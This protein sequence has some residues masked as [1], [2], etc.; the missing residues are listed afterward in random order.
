MR[1][2]KDTWTKL[3]SALLV[4]A[5]L[6]FAPGYPCCCGGGCTFCSG[7][8]PQQF[9]VVIIGVEERDPPRCGDCDEWNTTFILN[10]S[11]FCTDVDNNRDCIWQHVGGPCVGTHPLFPD[12]PTVELQIGDLNISPFDRFLKVTLSQVSKTSACEVFQRIEYNMLPPDDSCIG[13]TNQDVPFFTDG[14][15]V[16]NPD[17]TGV[18]STC[19]VT[20]L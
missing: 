6:K 13:F 7:E 18:N 3:A 19:T 9:E 16:G 5:Y 4:P 20:S 2:H 17:C 10:F 15:P 14:F 8:T 1:R 11:Q 12:G